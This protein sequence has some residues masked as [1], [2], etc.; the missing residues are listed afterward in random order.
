MDNDVNEVKFLFQHC[1]K[2]V[3]HLIV[4]NTSPKGV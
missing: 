1:S 4:G 2:N 3:H